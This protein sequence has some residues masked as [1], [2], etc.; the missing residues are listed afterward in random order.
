MSFKQWYERAGISKATA[1]RLLSRGE[2]PELIKLSPKLRG[3]TYDA[4]RRWRAARIISTA[5]A[6]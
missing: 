5:S 2:G 4:D 1:W 6:T 3:V